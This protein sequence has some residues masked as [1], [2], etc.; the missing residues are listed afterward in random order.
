MRV[1]VF[2]LNF[3][4]VIGLNAACRSFQRRDLE[5]D[6]YTKQTVKCVELFVRRV[7]RIS[8]QKKCCIK[9]VLHYRGVG[10]IETALDVYTLCFIVVLSFAVR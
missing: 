1:E 6:V 3:G 8:A 10:S 4:K 9:R 7:L 5:T 2:E